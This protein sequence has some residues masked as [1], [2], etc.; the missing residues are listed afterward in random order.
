MG[1]DNFFRPVS[2]FDLP[3]FAGVPSF[4]RLPHLGGDNPQFAAV[5]IG[6]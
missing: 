4:M 1:S 5:D 6:I 2:G 3:R